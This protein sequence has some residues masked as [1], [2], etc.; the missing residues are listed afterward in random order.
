MLAAA[1]A[2]AIAAA[3]SAAATANPTTW[4]KGHGQPLRT[5]RPL[6]DRR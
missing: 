4:Q 6:V 3:P 5:R 1:A 2:V